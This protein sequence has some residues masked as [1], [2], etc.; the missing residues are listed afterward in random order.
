MCSHP[1]TA[2]D[3]GRGDVAS[4]TGQRSRWGSRRPGGRVTTILAFTVRNGGI[5][6]IDILADPAGLRELDPNPL[7]G[8]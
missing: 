6:E 4:T 7:H 3:G 8:R 1:H 5:T 2:G